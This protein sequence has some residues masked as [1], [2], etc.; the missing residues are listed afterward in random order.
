MRTE[1]E[2]REAIEILRAA[3]SPGVDLLIW[4]LADPKPTIV[5]K[6]ISE[7][8]LGVRAYNCLTNAGIETIDQLLERSEV[9]LIRMKWMGRKQANAI[10]ALLAEY[11]LSMKGP[12]L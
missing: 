10:I 4:V 8:P 1:T 11:G 9:D 2:I 3:G 12:K 6:L 5:G 7:V